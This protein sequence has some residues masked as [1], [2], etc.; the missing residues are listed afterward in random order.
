MNKI[1]DVSNYFN[2]LNAFIKAKNEFE[3]RQNIANFMIVS[4]L[5]NSPRYKEIVKECVYYSRQF[6]LQKKLFKTNCID[7]IVDDFTGG[8]SVNYECMEV[9][10][11]YE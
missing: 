7:K 5:A 1:I 8:F 2:E 4:G 9:T 11:S 10:L 6:N 3:S